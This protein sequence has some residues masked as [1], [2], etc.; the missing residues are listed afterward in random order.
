M[1]GADL[2]LPGHSARVFQNVQA[3]CCCITDNQV[4]QPDKY[5]DMASHLRE[6]Q[7][8]HDVNVKSPVVKGLSCISFIHVIISHYANKKELYISKNRK[9][10]VC[11]NCTVEAKNQQDSLIDTLR[12]GRLLLAEKLPPPRETVVLTDSDSDPSDSKY[13]IMHYILGIYCCVCVYAHCVFD[14]VIVL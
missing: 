1:T 5:H 4:R 3:S 7:P 6:N 9:K 2:A 13:K 10:R 14:I 12:S 11:H 8:S